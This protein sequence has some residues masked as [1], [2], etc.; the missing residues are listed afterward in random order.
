MGV[1]IYQKIKRKKKENIVRSEGFETPKND[2][3]AYNYTRSWDQELTETIYGYEVPVPDMPPKE[4]IINYGKPIQEQVFRKTAFPKDF[5]SYTKVQ[6]E[7]FIEREHHRRK[8]GL[9]FY[10]K[11][12][13]VY[14]PGLFYYFMNYWPLATGQPTKFHMGDWKFFM[15]W[16]LVVMDPD[17]FGLIVFKCR[18]IGDTEKA[19]CMMYEYSTRVRNTINQMYDCRVEDDMKKTWRRLKIAHK[20]MVW[21]MKP[22]CTNDDP[23]NMFE[24]RTPKRQINESNSYID[25]NGQIVLDE[26]E[27]RELDSDL[28]YYTNTGGADGARVGRAYIDEFGKFK[29]INPNSL[30]ALMKKALMDDREGSLIGKALFTS[31]IEE[32]KG[33]DT[34]E[35]AKKLWKDSNPN[36]LDNEGR[37]L[38]G[39]I[40]IVRGAVDREPADRWGYVD[41]EAVVK[42]IKDRHQFLIDNKQWVTLITERRQDCL[43]IQD[44][45][46][47]IS[48]GSPFNLE[49]ITTR[50]NELEAEPIQQWVKGNLEWVDGIKPVPGN[51]KNINKRCR[52]YFEPHD[53]G[54][55]VVAW[56]PK[57]FN[58][59]ANGM[60]TYVKMPTPLNTLDFSCGIDPVAYKENIDNKSDED[61]RDADG[62]TST[63]TRSLAGLAVKRNLDLYIDDNK[64]ELFDIEG[65]PIDGG[66]NFKTNRYCCV[67]LFRHDTPSMNYEDWLKTVIYYGTDFLIEKNHSAGFNQYLET[68]GFLGY[69]REGGSG[70]SNYK[71]QQETSG[72]TATDKT[73]EAYFGAISE[74][75]NL[76]CNTIDIPLILEQLA[77]MEYDTR[78]KHDLGVAVGFCELLASAKMQDIALQAEMENQ[79]ELEY[80]EENT[81]GSD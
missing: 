65:N 5:K 37:T 2:L 75:T 14:I 74:L 54:R 30:W 35:V 46:S 36:K 47:N 25:E 24:F 16:M 12:K 71:G 41:E 64:E 33:G 56:H 60:E 44:V 10:I 23:S 19:L 72:L 50:T 79:E 62:V 22:L 69:Y 21:F 66:R 38:T 49:N 52:V 68:M 18:R 58:K 13:P 28:S 70:I 27:F 34:L 55:W 48:K 78:G 1:A 73:V 4:Q 63:K 8:H 15:I 11:G 81:F 17:I 26:Y 77:T 3:S 39:L 61:G 31:T 67:Y 80:F 42:R 20:R 7:T 53:E 51:P 45:F 76:W 9:W 29:Q 32:M 57:D 40:R 6:Q 59:M 43:T